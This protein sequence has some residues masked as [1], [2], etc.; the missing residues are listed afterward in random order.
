[1]PTLTT[2]SVLKRLQSGHPVS[3]IRCGDGEGI[4]LN[5]QAGIQEL[6]KC[7]QAVMRR[8]MGYYPSY[9]DIKAIRNNLIDAY[10]HADIIGMPMHKQKTNSNWTD[11]YR[12]L[13]ENVPVHTQD[14][15][16]IDVHYDF[17]T[18]GYFDKLITGQHTLNY[19]SC[20]NLDSQFMQ[21]WDLTVCNGFWIAPEAKFT[22]GYEGDVHYPTQ[23]N[24]VQRWMDVVKADLRILLVGAGVIGKIYCNWWR[25]RGGI[26]FDI[27]SVF[28]EWAGL[29]TRGDGKGLDV[30]NSDT[31]FK[32]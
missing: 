7:N 16:S 3:L 31:R 6:D 24:K 29:V 14:I 32:L 30:I 9:M 18:A 20:R 4:V 17:L 22:S 2:E 21:H 1:M 10:S 23:F 5:S 11:V 8:Q 26:A 28:D 12:I 19:I 25:D 13:D 27:G 15:C